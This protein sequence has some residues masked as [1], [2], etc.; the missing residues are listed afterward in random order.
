MRKACVLLVLTT[1]P[2]LPTPALGQNAPRVSDHGLDC[3]GS[4]S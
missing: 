2:L 1:L 4:S 3:L